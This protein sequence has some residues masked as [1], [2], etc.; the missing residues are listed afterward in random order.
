MATD[1]LLIGL[2]SPAKHSLQ[3]LRSVS[4]PAASQFSSAH[5][6][7]FSEPI[8]DSVRRCAQQEAYNPHSGTNIYTHTLSVSVKCCGD[9]TTKWFLNTE[10][11]NFSQHA[12]HWEPP[13]FFWRLSVR[14]EFLLFW[15]WLLCPPK[16]GF[17]EKP[18]AFITRAFL[19]LPLFDNN[20][21]ISFC[22]YLISIIEINV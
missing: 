15:K 13:Q 4:L 19:Q 6:P 16:T 22:Y 2:K 14:S 9:T 21:L 5:W 12:S 8:G 20:L 18:P 3:H 17:S 11:W 1:T 7:S 10:Y